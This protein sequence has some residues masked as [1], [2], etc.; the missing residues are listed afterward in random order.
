M[1][2]IGAACHHTQ[3][4]ADQ[5]SDVPLHRSSLS[6]RSLALLIKPITSGSMAMEGLCMHRLHMAGRVTGLQR[7][8][9]PTSRKGRL[10]RER[11]SVINSMLRYP[12]DT[13]D[14]HDTACH[15]QIPA[16]PLRADTPMT[17]S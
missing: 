8:S 15:Y 6:E 7:T 11:T 4:C 10:A 14:T 3:A 16:P 2:S 1:P 12:C 9:G 5:H 13:W 17:P